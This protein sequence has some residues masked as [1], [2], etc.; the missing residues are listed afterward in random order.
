MLP[1]VVSE[2][3]YLLRTVWNAIGSVGKKSRSPEVRLFRCR[4]L[5]VRLVG[6]LW[7]W[8]QMVARNEF[9]SDLYYRLNVFPVVIP[10]LRQRREDIR[11]LSPAFRRG[12]RTPYMQAN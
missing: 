10:P 3:R 9:R 5:Q 1:V 4:H 2:R 11:S 8:A 12:F 7:A 6:L